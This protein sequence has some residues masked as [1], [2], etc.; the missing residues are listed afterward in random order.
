MSDNVLTRAKQVLTLLLLA[1]AG[2]TLAVQVSKEFRTIEPV[3][4]RDG[5]NVLCTHATVRCPTCL[6]IERLTHNLLETEFAADLAAGTL[7]VSDVNYEDASMNDLA[8]R[9]G[10]A[11]ASVVLVRVTDGEIVGGK[12]LANESWKLYTDE[13]AFCEML[14]REIVA[15]RDGNFT[16][17]E[18]TSEEMIFDDDDSDSIVIP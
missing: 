1:F 3:R 15:A 18:R 4:L 16:S 2:V 17:Q 9:F 8:A 5:L 10:I 7:S 11:T 13:P 14:R 12:N 6:T